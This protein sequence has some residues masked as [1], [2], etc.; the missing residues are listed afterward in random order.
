MKEL[1]YGKDYK[2]PHSY[3][4]NYIKQEYLPEEIKNTSFYI[5]QNN[6]QEAKFKQLQESRQRNKFKP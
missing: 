1:G 4:D 2:Y 5:P 6:A 3:E